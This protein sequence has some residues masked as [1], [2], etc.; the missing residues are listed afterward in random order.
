L[1]GGAFG[2]QFNLALASAPKLVGSKPKADGGYSQNDGETSNDAFVVVLKEGVNVVENERRSSVEGG[3][4]FFIIV[5]GGLLTVL[6]LYQAK[7]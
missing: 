4:V 5:I 3:A 2:E 6:W 1:V 7:R